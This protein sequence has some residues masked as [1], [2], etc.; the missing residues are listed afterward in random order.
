M[1]RH[2]QYLELPSPSDIRRSIDAMGHHRHVWW[3]IV[4]LVAVAVCMIG[5]GV[6]QWEFPR[7][8]R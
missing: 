4:L 2:P 3:L 8:R 1:I 7:L 5:M 6:F